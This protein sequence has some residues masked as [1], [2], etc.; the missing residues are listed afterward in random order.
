M[1]NENKKNSKKAIKIF[2]ILVLLFA[3]LFVLDEIFF[4]PKNN[5]Q[6]INTDNTIQN[7]EN[8]EISKQEPKTDLKIE[9]INAGQADCT[10]VEN[11]GQVMLIDTGSK[12]QE[13][14]TV[15][16][17]KNKNIAK[18]NYIFITNP[19]EEHIGGLKIILEN[20]EVENIYLPS[21]QI[22]S[23]LFIDSVVAIQ[24]KGLK[25]KSPEEGA[26]FKLGDAAC[27]IVSAKVEP[28][29]IN[30]SSIIIKI[31]YGEKRFLFMSDAE[32]KT[33][34]EEDW[35]DIDVLKVGNHGSDMGTSVEFL[36]QTKPEFAIIT[37]DQNT[38]PDILSRLENI[39]AT[40]YNTN[41]NGTITLTTNGKDINIEKEK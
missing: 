6:N 41:Q 12:E 35:E 19:N 2:I 25:I 10:I 17:I 4:S 26:I 14:N 40:I 39:G 5:T 22:N 7:T 32:T 38:K 16:Y 30:Y 24:D 34:T 36:D 23:E 11:N 31:T 18:I 13:E 21:V 28:Q 29:D 33:E 9:Y 15:N 1:K 37:T 3:I 8:E 20:F 27:N